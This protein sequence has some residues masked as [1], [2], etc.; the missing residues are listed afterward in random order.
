MGH[1]FSSAWVHVCRRELHITAAW[2]DIRYADTDLGQAMDTD[3]V[4]PTEVGPT[5]LGRSGHHLF[6]QG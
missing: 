4:Y 2:I 1:T 6:A 3:A 5:V